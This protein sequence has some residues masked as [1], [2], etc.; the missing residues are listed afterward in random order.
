MS[1]SP[2]DEIRHVLKCNKCSTGEV[3][4]NDLRHYGCKASTEICPN[5]KAVGMRCESEYVYKAAD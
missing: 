5:C 4:Y 1:D 2:N 3:T